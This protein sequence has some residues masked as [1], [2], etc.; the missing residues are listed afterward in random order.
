M[1][2]PSI[3]ILIPVYNT[4]KYLR[5]CLD[6][7]VNQTIEN[8]EVI[9]V[10]DG[11]TDSSSSI[12]DE[13]SDKYEFVHV[14]HQENKGLW[15]TR[16][17][18]LSMANGD[19]IAWVDSDDYIDLSM[20]EDLLNFA[21]NENAEV[22]MCDYSFFPNSIKTK[23]KWFKPY[24]GSVDWSFIERNTQPWN[25]IV[26][27]DL[28]NRLD[29]GKWLSKC[30]DGSYSLVLIKA[31]GIVSVE[32]QYYHYRV[33][34]TSMSNN[35]TNL[36]HFE[37]NVEWT[38]NQRVA[39]ESVG[40]NEDWLEYYDYRVIYSVIQTMIVASHTNNKSKYRQYQ[41]IYRNM[42]KRKNK[43]TKTV[44]RNN[45]GRFKAFVLRNIIPFNFSIARLISKVALK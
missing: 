41:S 19:Y 25:K 36:T 21:F 17:R 35:M 2:N 27:R 22:V 28:L 23:E 1:I 38:T 5:E 45:H 24:L 13:F 8:K 16:C 33:G 40:L 26:K 10:D 20:Y 31:N 3:S 29:I 39:A 43:Y 15:E 7:I 44:L 14:V 12:V 34:H 6:S 4:E 9:I 18:L 11:S 32:K 37:D 30:G 42:K